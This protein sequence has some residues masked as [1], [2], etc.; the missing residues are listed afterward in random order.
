MARGV[1]LDVV[2]AP[3][4]VCRLPADAPVP[5]WAWTA[6]TFLTITRT[7]QELSIT[8]DAAVVPAD[9]PAQRGWRAFKVRGTIGFSVVGLLSS[10]VAPL[11]QAGMTVLS[12]STHDT[13]WF[14][15]RRDD[16]EHATSVLERAGH[17]VGV[18]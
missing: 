15:V 17:H 14:L 10:I 2:E 6:G 7:S 16:L 11:S 4:A 9:V 18:A 5:E 12:I 8:A 1:T 13:D 3:I